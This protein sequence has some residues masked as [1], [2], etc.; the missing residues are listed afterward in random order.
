M[1]GPIR[2]PEDAVEVAKTLEAEE[3]VLGGILLDPDAIGRVA[4][5]LQPGY[6]QIAA[7][8]VVYGS[9]TM[10]VYS[11]GSG[12]HGFTLDPSNAAYQHLAA[13]ATQVVSVSYGV[14]DGTATTPASGADVLPAISTRAAF[15]PSWWAYPPYGASMRQMRERTNTSRIRL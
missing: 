4:D 14:S 1:T 13:G 2:L 9:S 15:E 7:G 11:A 3:A 10:L 6:K 8:Y 12:V 5:V